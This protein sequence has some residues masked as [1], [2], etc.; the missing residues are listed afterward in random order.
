MTIPP[1][2]AQSC[3]A[4]VSDQTALQ[5]FALEVF[6][7][8]G[9]PQKELLSKY[10]YDAVGS[11]LFEAITLLPEYGLTRADERLLRGHAAEMAWEFAPDVAVA[12]LGAGN[13]RKAKPILEAISACQGSVPY[14]AVDASP[15]ALERCRE[16]MSG[17]PYVNLHA[18]ARCY[19]EGLQEVVERRA[20]GERLLVLFVG[21]NIGNFDRSVAD[22]FLARIRNCLTPGDA[23]LLGADLEKPPA[24]LLRAYD[25]PAGV[26]AA[27]NLNLLARINR[28]LSGDFELRNFAHEA[29]WCPNSRRIEMHLRSLTRQTVTIRGANC[30]VEFGVG[31][32]IWTESSHKFNP[33]ELS[34]MATR[35]GF[36]CVAQWLDEEW[37]FAENLWVVPKES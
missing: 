32:T 2:I 36:V 9:K 27:F 16:E 1:A 25:D 30:C 15:A 8:L 29:R 13:G 33:A 24:E 5:R 14:Y 37:P 12:E 18:I 6:G 10:L 28:E 3:P 35:A 17:L 11:A 20:P 21:S 34:G 19:L 31:E 26:T 7:G 23:L 4:S 22:T